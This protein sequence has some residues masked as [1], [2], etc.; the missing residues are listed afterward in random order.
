MARGKKPTRRQKIAMQA[1]GC[2]LEVWLIR[3]APGNE[4]H[5]I[6]RYTSLVKVIPA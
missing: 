4:I 2:S 3:K 5:L 6:H 1:A